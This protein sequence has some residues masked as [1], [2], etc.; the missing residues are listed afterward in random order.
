MKCVYCSSLMHPSQLTCNQ[1]GG[2][3]PFRREWA[4]SMHRPVLDFNLDIRPGAVNQFPLGEESFDDL[5]TWALAPVKDIE[6]MNRMRKR[7]DT[8]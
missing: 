7:F 6:W 8:R 3:A 4:S 1:C 5:Q 2:P